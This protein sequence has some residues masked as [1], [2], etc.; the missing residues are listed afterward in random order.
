MLEMK[1]GDPIDTKGKVRPVVDHRYAGN[2][3]AAYVVEMEDGF[4][5]FMAETAVKTDSIGAAMDQA[6]RRS[7]R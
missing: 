4:F 2:I 6:A 1:L 3:T 7:A 5:T